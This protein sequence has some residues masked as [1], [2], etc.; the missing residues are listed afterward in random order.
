MVPFK[1][2]LFGDILLFAITR[3]VFLTFILSLFVGLIQ[4]MVASQCNRQ[5]YYS[6]FGDNQ[7]KEDLYKFN[8]FCQQKGLTVG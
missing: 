7:L 2:K 6:A 3:S 4:I 5:L 8:Q 1:K